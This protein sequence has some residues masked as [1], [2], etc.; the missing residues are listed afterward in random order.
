MKE[1][2]ALVLLPV[3]ILIYS[4]KSVKDYIKLYGIS[5]LVSTEFSFR[6]IVFSGWQV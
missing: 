6:R 3:P 5:S 1:I 4:V 2:F